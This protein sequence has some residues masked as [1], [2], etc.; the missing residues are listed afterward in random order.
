MQSWI[1]S[2]HTGYNLDAISM[3]QKLTGDDR[4][5]SNLEKGFEYYISNF[6]ETDG[7][8]KYY[9]NKTYPIDIHCPAQCI[10][11][12]SKLNNFKTNQDLAAKS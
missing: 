12:F 8:P 1:D 9:H 2:F 6:F 3:Y 5:N 4:F 10:V 7:T 11:H